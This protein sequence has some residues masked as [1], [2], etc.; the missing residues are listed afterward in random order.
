MKMM[1]YLTV[2]DL[3][4]V[5]N[6]VTGE[7]LDFDYEKLEACIAAQYQ[8]GCSSDVKKQAVYFL[9][10]LAAAPAF[11]W[12]NKSSSLIAFCAFLLCNGYDLKVHGDQLASVF[13]SYIRGE[14]S[15]DEVIE[16]LAVSSQS[17]NLEGASIREIII[18][19]CSR[20]RESLLHFAQEDEAHN[21]PPASLMPSA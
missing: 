8:Y 20:E 11:E 4:W 19:L 13:D 2:H 21:K 1:R 3:V 16:L 14:M 15:P 6:V 5:N 17:K 12:G 9:Q 10:K 7:K 18:L